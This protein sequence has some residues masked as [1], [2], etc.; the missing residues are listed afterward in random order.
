MG[1]GIGCDVQLVDEYFTIFD[2]GIGI[3]QVRASLPQGFYFGALK[4]HSGFV[5]INNKIIPARS[6]IFGNDFDGF[7]SNVGYLF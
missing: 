7:F 1:K 2:P 4:H 6:A 5:F 3:F